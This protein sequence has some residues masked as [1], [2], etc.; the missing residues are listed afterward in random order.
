MWANTTG[1]VVTERISIQRFWT[2]IAARIGGRKTE[3]RGKVIYDSRISGC[4]CVGYADPLRRSLS[5]ATG[6]AKVLIGPINN[7]FI[8]PS[9][10]SPVLQSSTVCFVCFDPFILTMKAQGI[11]NYMKSYGFCPASQIIRSAGGAVVASFA[12]G[13]FRFQP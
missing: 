5:T 7:I 4:T 12:G 1:I 2:H 8:C 10:K 3:P 6:A 11:S 13:K 9:C